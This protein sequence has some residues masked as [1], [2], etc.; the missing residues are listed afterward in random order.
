MKNSPLVTAVMLTAD[1]PE[2]ARFAVQCFERQRYPN[3]RLV[4]CDTGKVKFDAGNHRSIWQ[5]R[6]KT[7]LG[8]LRN[9]VTSLARGTDIIVHWDDDDYSHPVRIA[10]QV[11]YLQT[12]GADC[13][14][15]NEMLFW[16]EDPGEAWL[17]S[18]AMPGWALGTSLCYWRRT[19]EDN[20]F[21]PLNHG[22]DTAWLRGVKCATRSAWTGT[23]ISDWPIARMMSSARM[24][25][26]IHAG[27]T[28]SNPAAYAL[29]NMRENAE[30]RYPQ[31]KRVAELDRYCESVFSPAIERIA[32]ETES[33]S[34]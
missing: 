23:I 8:T 15:Y 24:M 14:G 4:I 11:D 32:N 7:P 6:G 25:A 22:E 18:N 34:V 31:W 28:A 26:R 17:Y 10:E 13:V 5:E 9:I 29:D 19:W 27:N 3:K 2:M 30:S 21:P 16:R 20:P 33:R 12:S 1:R